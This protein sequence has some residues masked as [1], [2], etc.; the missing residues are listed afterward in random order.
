MGTY[1]AASFVAPA[2]GHGVTAIA[3]AAQTTEHSPPQL[4]HPQ[5]G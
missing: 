3:G 1:M 2:D 4:T 5:R